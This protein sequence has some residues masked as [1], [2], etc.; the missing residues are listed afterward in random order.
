MRNSRRILS[1]TLPNGSTVTR[2]CE[3]WAYGRRCAI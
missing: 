2:T 3:N 1:E